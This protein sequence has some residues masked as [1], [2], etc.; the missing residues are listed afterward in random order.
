MKQ[1]E[2]QIDHIVVIKEYGVKNGKMMLNIR[3]SARDREN[4][5]EVWIENKLTNK[6]GQMNLAV[7]YCIYFEID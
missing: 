4:P 3:D 7:R 6:P 1:S 2:D 5:D